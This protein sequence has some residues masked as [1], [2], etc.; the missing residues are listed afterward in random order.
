MTLG[1]YQAGSTQATFSDV[2][3]SQQG[4]NGTRLTL[5]EARR[6]L[7]QALADLQGLMQIDLDEEWGCP[8]ASMKSDESSSPRPLGPKDR[9][10]AR[11]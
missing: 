4:L 7:W 1:A 8:S 11:P 3:M 6:S 9:E 2:L 5:A 10:A